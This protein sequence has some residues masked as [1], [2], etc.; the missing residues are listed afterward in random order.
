MHLRI[1]SAGLIILA[2]LSNTAFGQDAKTGDL[3]LRD[4][5]IRATVP[6]APV[7]AGYLVIENTGSASDRLVE[8][9]AKFA[10][11]VE[12]HTMSMEGGVMK[13]RRLADGIDIVAG[14]TVVLKPGG[15]HIMFIGPKEPLTAGED[16]M[17]TLSF[18]KAGVIALSIPVKPFGYKPQVRP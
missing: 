4:A 3:A 10:E 9:S 8:G 7:A 14:E 1:A 13:M 11:R 17:V 18:E 5:F 15:M 6:G 16:K 2:I 12:F